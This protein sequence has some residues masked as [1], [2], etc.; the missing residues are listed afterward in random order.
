MKPL[1]SSLLAVPL[2]ISSIVASAATTGLSPE[3]SLLDGSVDLHAHLFM[4]EGAGVDW[5]GSFAGPITST[6]WEDKLHSRVNSE[7]LSVSGHS[8]VVVA[9]Y[10]HPLF[11]GSI[12]ESMERQ[13]QEAQRFVGTNPDWALAK[14]CRQARELLKSGKRVLLLSIEGASRNLDTPEAIQRWID[15]EGISIVAPLHFTND[16]IGGPSLLPGIRGLVEPMGW[17][18]AW[19]HSRGEDDVL[20]NPRGL[21]T[22]GRDLIE[23]L[24]QRK[25]WI[26]LSHASEAALEPIYPILDGAAQPALH[27]HTM[28]RRHY[29]GERGL[30]EKQI[31]EAAARN[32]VIG[33]IPSEDQMGNARRKNPG[34]RSGLDAYVEQLKFVASRMKSRSVAMGSDVN[35]PLDFLG[36]SCPDQASGPAG[37]EPFVHYGD[38]P[39]LKLALEHEQIDTITAREFLDRC[40]SR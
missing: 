23:V 6:G 30:S 39:R 8:I 7:T 32:G 10:T 24:V 29:P 19:F 31:G 38:M 11:R 15:R 26:D 12:E 9:L 4:H 16:W 34:C 13:L 14:S 35:A 5:L 33:L 17:L 2:L 37:P 36:P 21:T 18:R 22:R 27:T 28:L 40:P 1:L 3:R 25:I 20:R